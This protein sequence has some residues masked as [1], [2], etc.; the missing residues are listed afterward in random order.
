MSTHHR[1]AAHHQ[2]G[3]R[4]LGDWQRGD[5]QRGDWQQRAACRDQVAVFDETFEGRH[6]SRATAIAQRVCQ[7]C[8]VRRVCLADA[9]RTEAGESHRWGVRG[10]LLPG[11]C[12]WL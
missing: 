6:R 7:E 9:L 2:R 5:W 11:E 3:D 8:P 1:P 10:G 12:T 4:Q